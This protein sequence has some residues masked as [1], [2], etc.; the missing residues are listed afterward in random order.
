[1][2]LGVR[3]AFFW[4]FMQLVCKCTSPEKKSSSRKLSKVRSSKK[5]KNDSDDSYVRTDAMISLFLYSFMDT[6]FSRFFPLEGTKC[7]VT[8]RI[9]EIRR[10]RQQSCCQIGKTSCTAREELL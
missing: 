9:T 3:T 7:L 5:I 10:L 2:I 8:L 1:M 4:A 6:I